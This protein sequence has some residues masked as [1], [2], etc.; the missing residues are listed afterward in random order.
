MASAL[1]R[2]LSWGLP[3]VRDM[4]FLLRP[5]FTPHATPVVRTRAVG[6]TTPEPRPRSITPTPS[7]PS[8]T[9][10]N[11][12]SF[13]APGGASL[14]VPANNLMP[15]IMPD[16]QP[17]VALQPTAPE[18]STPTPQQA[19]R[20]GALADPECFPRSVL[21]V[22]APRAAA[23]AQALR[24]GRLRT[25]SPQRYG[26]PL[27]RRARTPSPQRY[28]APVR[29]V[30]GICAA[31]ATPPASLVASSFPCSIESAVVNHHGQIDKERRRRTPSPQHFGAP[32]NASVTAV[33]S[34]NDCRGRTPP[35]QH[36]GAPG[37]VSGQERGVRAVSPHRYGAPAITEKPSIL[38][39]RDCRRRT[40]SPHRYGASRPSTIGVPSGVATPQASFVSAPPMP[41]QGTWAWPSAAISGA[42]AQPASMVAALNP[43]PKPEKMQRGMSALF[44]AL[45]ESEIPQP[46]LSSKPDT[47][48][49]AAGSG[50]RIRSSSSDKYGSSSASAL[51]P[52][53]TKVAVSTLASISDVKFNTR[54]PLKLCQAPPDNV[55]MIENPIRD[56][57]IGLIAIA[58][59]QKHNAELLAIA[60]SNCDFLAARIAE[61]HKGAPNLQAG[62][63]AAMRIPQIRTPPRQGSPNIAERPLDL[64]AALPGEVLTGDARNLV[65]EQETLLLRR[66]SEQSG[67]NA[68][69]LRRVRSEVQQLGGWTRDMQRISTKSWTLANESTKLK[70]HLDSEKMSIANL[71]DQLQ[72]VQD[73]IHMHGAVAGISNS[74][75]VDPQAVVAARWA[76]ERAAKAPIGAVVGMEDSPDNTHLKSEYT[77][78]RAQLQDS[79]QRSQEE[80]RVWQREREELTKELQRLQIEQTSHRKIV[81]LD[82]G[83][84]L[85]DNHDLRTVSK[86]TLIACDDIDPATGGTGA[87]SE[88][89]E[90]Q[91][92]CEFSLQV[93]KKNL[94]SA[95]LAMKTLEGHQD[96]T[97]VLLGETGGEDNQAVAETVYRPD[98]GAEPSTCPSLAALSHLGPS[99]C[100]SKP[101]ASERGFSISEASTFADTPDFHSFRETVQSSTPVEP[102]AEWRLPGAQTSLS[103]LLLSSSAMAGPEDASTSS[104][105]THASS[106]LAQHSQFQKSVPDTGS[107]STL[108]LEC[109]RFDVF[110]S[111]DERCRQIERCGRDQLRQIELCGCAS[112]AGSSPTP[113]SARS[114]CSTGPLG[115]DNRR[116]MKG[117]LGK[118][119]DWFKAQKIPPE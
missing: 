9:V 11:E 60:K 20:V 113:T 84:S 97:S 48:R 16:V 62:P 59:R 8:A 95:M 27:E 117:E 21:A 18:A 28:G 2:Q 98:G 43:G 118:L 109:H 10:L 96:L 52:I 61:E 94:R 65:N 12:G 111:L 92:S 1:A 51:Q 73:N 115:V 116:K 101:C 34:R 4:Q 17:Q 39:D 105:S 100:L 114:T 78:L 55:S 58:N 71:T 110:P 47:H 50:A 37:L 13:V 36:F 66:I 33:A 83:L 38:V 104:V 75:A 35:P 86:P 87:E 53:A 24:Q 88:V 64:P 46:R 41:P 23:L 44:A 7:R 102:E 70:S 106:Q 3:R 57:S 89:S 31:T 91:E 19:T 68:H 85:E 25:P 29:S 108:P 40:S 99:L 77:L 32:V 14:V 49:C 42:A 72:S 45:T 69:D 54:T 63:G 81:A 30:A 112:E 26:A 22:S 56:E 103:S 6:V 93:L 67:Q 90:R 5:T 80:R 119:R 79:E 76:A 74:I 82:Q 15:W 107:L